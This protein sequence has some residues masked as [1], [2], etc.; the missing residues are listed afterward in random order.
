MKTYVT[1]FKIAA[2]VISLPCGF[3]LVV[4]LNNFNVLGV[5]VFAGLLSLFWG[6]YWLL[7]TG[8]R[9][10]FVVSFSIV[11]VLW[12][13]LLYQ[14]I[15]RVNFV[16]ENGGMERVDGQGSPLAF[17]LGLATEQLF[18]IPLSAV[19]IVGL[20]QWLRPNKALDPTP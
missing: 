15:K 11:A 18:F 20:L 5:L 4:N 7:R 13:P 6:L 9:F 1:Y 16:L 10:A 8:K 2:A 19:V 12:L 14:T 17:L 3:L